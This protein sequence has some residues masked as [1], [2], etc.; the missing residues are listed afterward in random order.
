MNPMGLFGPWP[1]DPPGPEELVVVVAGGSLAGL[2]VERDGDQLL[3]GIPELPRFRG[4]RVRLLNLG[5]GGYKQP[6]QLQLL[7]YLLSL[8]MEPDLVLLL[9]GFNEVALPGPDN[10][11][12]G[13]T[14]HFPRGWDLL[15]GGPSGALGSQLME[16]IMRLRGERRWWRGFFS[17]WPLRESNLALVL[18]DVVSRRKRKAIARLQLAPREDPG[19][20][21]LVL[22]GPPGFARDP[23]EAVVES[24]A[25]WERASGLMDALCRARGIEFHHFLQPNQY[26][27][28]AQPLSPGDQ[29]AFHRQDQPYRLGAVQGYPLLR[30][31]GARLRQGGVAFHDLS[32]LFR[33]DP[34][35]AYRDDCCHLS[36]YGARRV[37]EAI[38]E[39]LRE[40][41]R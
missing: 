11:A 18:W 7:T 17:R 4:R 34:G 26:D 13:V 38:L 8:G 21:P 36:E 14:G 20:L 22:A 9:D 30:E 24:V 12:K 1:L 15:A 39:A 35:T 6:Q 10:L 31:A 3:R 25:L 32:G 5:M 37:G 2:Q 27:P 29:A 41:R 33:G 40:S 19:S 23:R 16:E 28:A